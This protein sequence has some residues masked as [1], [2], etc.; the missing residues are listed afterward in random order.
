MDE[1][2][3]KGFDS[4]AWY[5]LIGPAGLPTEVVTRWSIA[6]AA[7]GKDKAGMDAINATGCDADILSPAQTVEKIRVDSAKWGKVVKDAGIRAE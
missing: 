1:V 3:L 5:G 6:L 7:A 4:N 2:G